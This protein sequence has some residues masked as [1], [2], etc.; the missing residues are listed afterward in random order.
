MNGTSTAILDSVR[1]LTRHSSRL[2]SLLRQ[3]DPALLPS[4]FR[5]PTIMNEL[6]EMAGVNLAITEWFHE[7]YPR[8]FYAAAAQALRDEEGGA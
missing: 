2:L 3:T 6:K 1:A 8:A 7:A 4:I 5:E